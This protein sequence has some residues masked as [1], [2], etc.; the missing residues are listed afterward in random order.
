MTDDPVFDRAI[1]Y[2]DADGA[3]VYRASSFGYCIGALVRARLGITPSPP[4]DL[5]L[6]RYQEGHD[7]EREVLAAGLGVDWVEVTKPSELERFGQVVE[8]QNGERQVE[9]ELR[10]EAKSGARV[11][12]CHPD[13]IVRH[14]SDKHMRVAEVKFFGP[15]LYNQTIAGVEKQGLWGLGQGRAWQASIEMLTTKLPLL[16]II[17]QKQTAEVDGA[18]VVKGLASPPVVY[19]FAP[20]DGYSF[21]DVKMRAA[22]IEG[23][24]ARGQ[25]PP[26]V[27]PFDYP[28]GYWA[29][30]EQAEK[31]PAIEDEQLVHLV[32]SY[33][34]A[35][36]KKAAH[37]EEA[38]RIKADIDA[39][40]TEVGLEGGVCGGWEIV[41]TQARKGNVSWS[42]AWKALPREVRDSVDVDQYRGEEV[43]AGLRM[44]KQK[45][46]DDGK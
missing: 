23:W 42:A 27:V 15:D 4:P 17:G 13:A 12:R 9:T 30:H 6:E 45:G 20:E 43:E 25:M 21:K 44:T 36:S 28:C 41:R 8:G 24:V 37:E 22:E 46:T 38:A 1:A 29:E 40:L 16:Y 14:G 19:E 31:A 26:C 34:R 32:E 35:M 33:D 39:R 10:W 2:E 5:M 7:W 18:R 11:V 3:V